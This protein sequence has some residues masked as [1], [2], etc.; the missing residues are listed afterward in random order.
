[1]YVSPYSK[2]QIVFCM[3]TPI[4]IMAKQRIN[5]MKVLFLIFHVFK[6]KLLVSA[7]YMLKMVT[8]WNGLE[9]IMRFQTVNVREI[10]A[11]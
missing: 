9:I 8:T 7:A 10:K 4:S 2:S 1:M 6:R 11:A 5:A 3:L